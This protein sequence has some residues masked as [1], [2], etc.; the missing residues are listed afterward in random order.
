MP[1]THFTSIYRVTALHILYFIPREKDLF[2]FRRITL[3][4]L[5]KR[6]I[7]QNAYMF[8]KFGWS[9]PRWLRPCVNSHLRGRFSTFADSSLPVFL[10][11]TFERFKFKRVFEKIGSK[12][13][14]DQLRIRIYCKKT[15]QQANIHSRRNNTPLS[16]LKI[17]RSVNICTDDFRK[18]V[19]KLS[20]GQIRVKASVGWQFLPTFLL[21][22]ARQTHP[23]HFAWGW[24]Q[25]HFF[26]TV[27]VLIFVLSTQQTTGNVLS[28][29]KLPS[30]LCRSTESRFWRVV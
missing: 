30:L 28:S 5:E 19:S 25:Y 15:F 21:Y 26:S 23:R 20:E 9:C 29:E 6:L 22:G 16:L 11:K 17:A 10:E 13:T 3:F 14:R 1:A 2:G 12:P 24:K 4:P 8:S 7:A 27:F 18:G